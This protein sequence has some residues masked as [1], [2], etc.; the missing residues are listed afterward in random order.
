MWRKK[1]IILGLSTLILLFTNCTKDAPD[2]IQK[3]T[4]MKL[5]GDSYANEAVDLIS[6]GDDFYLLCNYNE[7]D[8]NKWIIVRKIDSYGNTIAKCTFKG[9][10]DQ[11]F[12]AHDFTMLTDGNL[13]IA[14]TQ[15][16]DEDSLFDDICVLII[17]PQSISLGTDV[18][19]VFDSI[20]AYAGTDEGYQIEERSTGGVV[21]FGTNIQDDSET[22]QRIHRPLNEAYQLVNPSYNG[23]TGVNQVGSMGNDGSGNYF[24]P[25]NGEYYSE[26]VADI[27]YVNSNGKTVS[28]YQSE[29]SGLFSEVK[30]NSDGTL[31]VCGTNYN[32]TH[33][34][35]DAYIAKLS[36][37][38]ALEPV[39]ELNL[40]GDGNDQAN[41]L[42]ISSD[43][44]IFVGGSITNS[45]GDIDIFVAH[46]DASGNLLNEKY[47]GGTD[48]DYAAKIFN[49]S[50]S[51]SFLILG[52]SYFEDYSSVIL[53]K[54]TF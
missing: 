43:N 17:N 49:G 18:A 4:F 22:I 36:S 28:A 8:E 13:A 51:S 11:P 32:G 35:Y 54:D 15:T 42:S 39:W 30:V 47:Y 46:I 20:Y 27:L 26:Y 44:T 9:K 2:A 3:D 50:N 29:I 24:L 33:G 38:D 19:T 5:Y 31:L 34:K 21:I 10:N 6:D 48:N 40:G 45:S 37:I 14:G 7:D 12:V 52:T 53:I 16:V 25:G 23:I 1:N 41:C